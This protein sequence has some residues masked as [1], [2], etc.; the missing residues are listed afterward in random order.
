MAKGDTAKTVLIIGGV[1]LGAYI[2]TRPS[3]QE[4]VQ[5]IISGGG[6]PGINLALEIPGISGLDLTG[7]TGNLAE[8]V[9]C[10]MPDLGDLLPSEWPNLIPDIPSLPPLFPE[11]DGSTNTPTDHATWADVAYSLPSWAKGTAAVVGAGLIGYGGYTVI[12]ATAPM[13]QA[14]GTQAARGIGGAG[15][16]LKNLL[17][18]SATKVSGNVFKSAPTA[19]T[20][21]TKTLARIAPKALTW[22]AIGLGIAEFGYNLARLIKG[23]QI[24][25]SGAPVLD[26]YALFTGR[27]SLEAPTL[28]T[29]LFSKPVV[30]A[31]PPSEISGEVFSPFGPLEWTAPAPSAE[32]VTSPREIYPEY[33]GYKSIQRQSATSKQK[34]VQQTYA[35][36]WTKV[37][38]GTEEAGKRLW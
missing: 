8:L 18:T 9:K 30:A 2:L 20:T 32:P 34:E 27:L 4:K 23:E 7:L 13:I 35:Q 10:N 6:F 16:L 37:A 26:L 14:I 1:A 22:G 12:K 15:T 31:P 21:T 17:T 28:L 5:E 11:G 36:T 25:P 38:T 33:Q 29:A 24:F 19:V 3:T